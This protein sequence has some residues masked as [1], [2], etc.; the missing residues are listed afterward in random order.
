MR[1]DREHQFLAGAVVERAREQPSQQGDVAQQQQPIGAAALVLADQAGK[2]LRLAVAKTNGG[3]GVARP[4][5][6]GHRSRGRLDRATERTD[7]EAD[8]DR[9]VVVRI[10][11][12]FDIELQPHIDVADAVRNESAGARRGGDDGILVADQHL[13]LILVLHADL[14]IRQGREI[15]DLTLEVD[16]DA[17]QAQEDVVLR[18]VADVAEGRL[19][20]LDRIRS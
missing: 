2:Q 20:R 19:E 7:F 17:T 18:E 11:G 9:D 6:V 4:D 14:R 12:G 10:D 3:R 16:G 13:G 8:P 5:L 1:R 15:T